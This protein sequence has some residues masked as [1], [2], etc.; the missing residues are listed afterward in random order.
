MNVL[1]AGGCGINMLTGANP[2]VPYSGASFH[3]NKL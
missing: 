3:D 1:D 2:I